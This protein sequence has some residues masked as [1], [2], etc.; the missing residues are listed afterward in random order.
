MV[1]FLGVLIL[2]C[3]GGSTTAFGQVSSPSRGVG[4]HWGVIAQPDNAGRLDSHR[5]G[6]Q[7]FVSWFGPLE[8]Y[9]AFEFLPGREPYWQALFNVRVRPLGRDGAKSV[10]YFGGGGVLRGSEARAGL[11]SG[12]EVPVRQLRPFIELRYH[13]TQ[14]IDGEYELIAGLTFPLS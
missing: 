11:L 2:L 4:F 14:L 13:W 1:R 6:V 10:W 9:P 7:Y 12:V 5:L 3:V 8:F